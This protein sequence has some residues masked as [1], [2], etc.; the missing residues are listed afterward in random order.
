METAFSL[1]YTEL[2]RN[3]KI[4][5]TELCKLMSYN[6]AKILGLDG[7]VIRAGVRADITLVNPDDELTVDASLFRSKGKNSLFDGWRLMGR[8][9]KVFVGGEEKII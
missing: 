9:E 7:G 4:E 2:V 1:A 5:L 3:E 8:I 6:P